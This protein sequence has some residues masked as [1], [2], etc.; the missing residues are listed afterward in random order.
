[1]AR[2]MKGCWLKSGMA[3]HAGHRIEQEADGDR[4]GRLQHRIGHDEEQ[5]DVEGHQRTDDVLGLG[6]L[7]AGGGDGRGHLGIDHRDAGVE[8][9]GHPAGDQAGDHAAFADGEVPSHVFAD[10]HDADAERPD[11]RRAEHAQQLQPFAALPRLYCILA[12][13]VSPQICAVP[14]SP[15]SRLRERKSAGRCHRSCRCGRGRRASAHR[16]CTE[17]AQAAYSR[18]FQISIVASPSAS[19]RSALR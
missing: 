16:T 12:I 10:E 14:A 13:D 8:Q 6:I 18:I 2:M 9:P 19:G 7:P 3:L 11:V 1:M 15:R 4:I 5:A 17:S